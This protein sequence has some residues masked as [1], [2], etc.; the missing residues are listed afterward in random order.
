MATELTSAECDTVLR[1]SG[2][3][4]LALT[5]GDEAYSIPESFGYDGETVYFQLVHTSESKKME[6][7]ETTETATLTVYDEQAVKSVLVQGP[8]EHVPEDKQP[9]AATTITQNASIPTLNVYP[10]TTL[11]DTTMNYYQLAPTT[12]TGREFDQFSASSIDQ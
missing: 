10:E 11:E 1:E 9:Q 8:V 12:I 5:D 2:V 3:G 7:L 4:V 6:F